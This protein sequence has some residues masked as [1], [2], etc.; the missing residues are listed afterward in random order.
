MNR[1]LQI[2]APCR[3]HFG[4]LRFAQACGPSFGGLGMMLDQPSTVVEMQQAETWQATGPNAERALVFAQQASQHWNNVSVSPLSIHV[5]QAPLAH[6]GLGSGTQLALAIAHGV[7]CLNNC[8]SADAN[9]LSVAVGRGQR[10]AIGSHGFLH[11]GLLWETGRNS[12]ESLATLTRRLDVPEQWRV[13]LIIP[14]HDV[15]LHGTAE[16]D[17]FAQ[18]PPVPLDITTKLQQLAE[19]IIL[20]AVEQADF[21][22][23]S[24]AIY[25]YGHLAGSCFAHVQGGPYATA[26]VAR[27]VERLRSL[28]L[29]GV[30]QSSWG[31]TIFAFASDESS[32]NQW[33]DTL[34]TLPEFSTRTITVAEPSNHG[35]SVAFV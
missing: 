14:P 7:S 21:A 27:C 33:R 18:L 26:S 3:L 32:A 30:G 34:S 2:T 6:A 8:P 23:F 10:S 5:R 13:L 1:P 25:E 22:A 35:A 24:E 16:I 31:P 29:Y 19:S 4:L 11:G 9:D 12:Q 20:P 17:A 15:G 28:G